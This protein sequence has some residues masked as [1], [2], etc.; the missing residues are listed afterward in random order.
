MKD[1]DASRLCIV[2][3]TPGKSGESDFNESASCET[4]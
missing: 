2:H 4:P 3:E 1:G